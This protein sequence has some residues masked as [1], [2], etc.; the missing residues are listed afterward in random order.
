[1]LN[2]T[3]KFTF[4]I[5]HGKT[6]TVNSWFCVQQLQLIHFRNWEWARSWCFSRRRHGTSVFRA[7]QSK[8]NNS[9]QCKYGSEFL[10]AIVNLVECDHPIR[11]GFWMGWF[12][13]H[14]KGPMCSRKYKRISTF[15]VLESEWISFFLPYSIYYYYFFFSS[16]VERHYNNCFFVKWP[17]AQESSALSHS[18]YSR[19][20]GNL[21][22]VQEALQKWRKK[23]TVKASPSN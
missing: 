11:K 18:V 14:E 22:A 15:P 23:R 20:E 6:I 13:Q 3:S 1:M 4:E 9:Q 2:Q 5:R 16:V 7:L 17:T 12:Y 19:N 8:Q 10:S 21:G